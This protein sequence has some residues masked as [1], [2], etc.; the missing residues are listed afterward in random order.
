LET[1]QVFRKRRKN[2]NVVT[3][4]DTVIQDPPFA[5]LI[6]SDTRASLV[7]LVLR[8][9]L[10]YQWIEASL[11]KIGTPWMTGEG[12]KGF[13]TNAVAIPAEGRPVIAFDW[14]R[15]FIQFLLDTG[16][17]TW[18]AKVVAYGELLIGIAL[19]LGLF[20]GIAAFLGGLMNWNF[21]M[22]GA[23]STNGMLFLLSVLIILAWKVAGYIG[24]D[25][26]ILPYLGT[27]W[28]GKSVEEPKPE[29]VIV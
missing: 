9:W 28:R 11:H 27:P 5:Q 23:A 3:H 4:K 14:Y 26:F 13:W 22:A 12:L 24:L 18:F 19:I 16:S 29:P 2:E 8:V 25:Y 1:C 10:G 21:I 20:T 15:S 6:F 17:Y 7:W